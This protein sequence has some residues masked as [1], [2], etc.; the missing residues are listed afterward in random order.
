[1][2][3]IPRTTRALL[4]GIFGAGTFFAVFVAFQGRWNDPSVLIAI[5]VEFGLLL[6][7]LFREPPEIPEIFALS[8]ATILL[9]VISALMGIFTEA[10]V[11]VSGGLAIY[12]AVMSRP[13]FP[14]TKRALT[15][16]IVIGV[17]MTFLGIYL[18]LKIGVVYFIG[19]ELLGALILSAYGRYTP[20]ENTV[21]VAIANSSAYI[22]VGVLV[23]FPAIAIF[24]PSS[25]ASAIITYPFIVLVT[26]LSA[27]FG[28][29]LLLPFREQFET[30][31]WPQVT[32]QANC[33]V[34]LAADPKSKENVVGGMVTGA[35][36]MGTTR[37]LEGATGST[38]SSLPQALTPIIP[39][40]GNIPNWIGV[41][42]SP[43]L[44][45]VGYFVGW[46]RTLIMAVGTL[47]TVM[48]WILIE[49]AA[50]IEY[51][52]HLHRPEIIYLVLGVFVAVI[53]N[54]LV[55]S[56]TKE[57]TPEEFEEQARNHKNT[58]NGKE[59]DYHLIEKPHKTEELP[60]L[61]RVRTELFSIEAL[62]EE[63]RWMVK[64]PRGY[65]KSKRGKMPPWIAFTSLVS[66]II[67][68]IFIFS[69]VKPFLGIEIPWLL[70][71]IG[72]PLALISAYFTARAI[73]ETGMLAGYISD[74]I[75]I[76]A[77]LLF[78]TTFQAITTFM[79]MLGGLQD[80]AIAL[81][82]HLKLGRI[83]GVRGRSI[84]KA[85]AIGMVLGTLIGSMI[86]YLLY[87]TY[88]FGGAEFP[89]PVS[90][91]FGFLVISI[92]HIGNFQ[93][94]G[95]DQLPDMPFLLAFLYLMVFAIIGYLTGR[96]LNRRG[97]SA[98]SLAVGLLIPPATSVTMLF[99]GALNY[100]IEKQ[101]RGKDLDSEEIMICEES[102]E[103]TSRILS[104]V[105]AGEA[106]VTVFL[107]LTAAFSMLV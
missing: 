19:A 31:P 10:T 81:L 83:T 33:I 32:P 80:A 79:A 7:V 8:L 41:T 37:F 74:I 43:L 23:T 34:S 78:R 59:R 73:S 39:E 68:G 75:A 67:V 97:F 69:L 60:K 26:G 64:D 2:D 65:M 85:V 51:G 49:G 70:F 30:D 1:M 84:L 54:D 90:Q 3:Q 50:P 20:E 47:V 18:A 107:V 62:K 100:R 76:P 82:V 95:V 96:E 21:V 5:V 12:A 99:G 42:N 38:L 103:R 56:R 57:L 92:S 104:G 16:G 4:L 9:P 58:L 25:Y 106:I 17:I 77:I 61:L 55:S 45:G 53:L 94:P 102:E 91:L 44:A 52:D 6:G 40:A 63:I 88:G 29:I 101:R 105:V 13:K 35:S 14:L 22:S 48:I 28:L 71:V 27:V 46:K 87:R 72:T 24:T 89:A 66:F 11:M 98:I 15:S 93:L 86:T 36:W